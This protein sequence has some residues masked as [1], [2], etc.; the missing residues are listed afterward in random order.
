MGEEHNVFISWSRQRS[1]WVAKALRVL[2]PVGASIR[3]AL[4]V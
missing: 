1:E 4:D 3:K 2:A